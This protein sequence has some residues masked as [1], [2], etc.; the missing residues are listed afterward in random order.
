M[1]NVHADPA[2]RSPKSPQEGDNVKGVAKIFADLA[3]NPVAYV[4]GI[5]LAVKIVSVLGDSNATVFIL[6]AFPVVG[7]TV[8]SKSPVGKRVQ[9]DLEAQLPG[10][11]SLQLKIA[12]SCAA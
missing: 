3:V 10:A 9:E 11:S 1:C 5:A 8:L 4:L 12:A 2:T 6:A 7:L